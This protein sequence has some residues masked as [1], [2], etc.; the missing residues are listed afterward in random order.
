MTAVLEPSAVQQA[1]VNDDHLRKLLDR[2]ERFDATRPTD[3]E[4]CDKTC[5]TLGH[6]G[7]AILHHSGHD[8]VPADID[9]G[10]TPR[11]ALQVR[12]VRHDSLDEGSSGAVELGDPGELFV[13]DDRVFFTVDNARRLAAK[14]LEAAD[15]AEPEQMLLASEVRIG[16]YLRVGHKW[17]KVY[18]VLTDEASGSVQIGVIED[19]DDWSDFDRRDENPEDFELTDLVLVRRGGDPR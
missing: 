2:E 18:M 5:E 1:P 15:R 8:F 14:L 12:A 11:G 17:I 7:D 4:W 6:F 19:E 3:P 16:D 10:M 9:F 13:K